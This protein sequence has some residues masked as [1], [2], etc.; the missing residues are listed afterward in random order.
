MIRF[1]GMR[2]LLLVVTLAAG[3]SVLGPG[4]AGCGTKDA[5]PETDPTVAKP[6]APPPVDPASV[7]TAAECDEA[8]RR[9]KTIVPDGVVGDDLDKSD[10]LAMPREVVRCLMTVSS[11]PEADH[12][13]AAY[14]KSRPKVAGTQPPNVGPPPDEARANETDCRAAVANV[15]KIIPDMT[16]VDDEMIRD[17]TATAT[18]DEVRCLLAAKT[19][20]DLDA[21]D[22]S[23]RD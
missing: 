7:P 1:A 12:C 11:E 10:C 19:T 13:V 20:E 8:V 3:A 23:T 22:P 15:R 9:M 5:K 4:L 14:E 21:C 17:C 6:V 18:A 16:G 2:R